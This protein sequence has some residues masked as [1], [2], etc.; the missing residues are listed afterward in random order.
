M[1]PSEW[2]RRLTAHYLREDGPFGGAPLDWIDATPAELASAAGMPGARDE[3]VQT[4]FLRQFSY[5]DAAGWLDGR[6]ALPPRDQDVPGYFRYLVLTALVL[7]TDHG[8]GQT[9]DFRKRLGELLGHM[10]AMQAVGGVNRLWGELAAWSEARRAAGHPI[11]RVILPDPGGMTRIGVA[12]RIAF[13][14]WKDRQI[15]TG[16]LARL[17]PPMR[18]SPHRLVAELSRPQYN[19]VCSPNVAATFD[20]FAAGLA[21]G[22]ADLADHRFWRLVES[23]SQR[24]QDGRRGAEIDRW[25][26]EVV[27][28]GIERDAVDV[29][30]VRR[31]ARVQA[32]EPI[33]TGAFDDFVA[34]ESRALPGRLIRLREGGVILLSEIA[35]GAWAIDDL[36]ASASW[37]SVVLSLAD[38]PATRAGLATSWVAVGGGW[39]AS[40]PVAT[41]A[42]LAALAGL[43][44]RPPSSDR[45]VDLGLEGGVSTARGSWLGRP[46]Y[47]PRVRAPSGATLTVE[48]I[49]GD[50]TSLGIDDRGGLSAEAPLTGAWKLTAHF[51]GG[52]AQ[53]RFFLEADASERDA[54]RA[55]GSGFEV[56]DEAQVAGEAPRAPAVVPALRSPTPPLLL[57]LMETVYARGAA[58]WGEAEFVELLDPVLPDRRGA[59][60]VMRAFAEAGWAEAGI[61]RGWRARRWRLLP[62]RLVPIGARTAL[63]EGAICA[64]ARRRLSEAARTQGGEVSASADLVWSPDVVIARDIDIDVMAGAMGW[65]VEVDTRPVLAA[66][67]ACWTPETRTPDGRELAG[68]WS[69]EAGGFRQ[70]VASDDAWRLER[71]TRSRGDDRDLFRLCGP[72]TTWCTSVRTAAIVEA[73]RRARR[74]L[75]SWDAGALI[76]VLP[77]GHLPM[78]LARAL[79]RAALRQTGPIEAGG[80]RAYR[81]PADREAA[82]WVAGAMGPAVSI[83]A[84][85]AARDLLG[86]VVG[87]RRR[88]RPAVWPPGALTEA[89]R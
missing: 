66:A 84:T 25:R 64:A 29:R 85:D 1:S 83:P 31:E 73:H 63:V 6:Y 79:R 58:S 19:G 44:V 76:S 56:V 9:R 69:F 15:L 7:S 20:D 3:D 40:E 57:D 50:T 14:S 70:A 77:G 60:D 51:P 26:F 18:R 10:G 34:A 2:E 35:G 11:R 74:P 82:A 17:T 71:W 24:L 89:L 16:I 12:V 59:W 41:P 38:G 87:A 68:V 4:A 5:W 88:G 32:A 81:Y 78:P 27:F 72:D 21:A 45:L 47:L 46:G 48:Q 8:A 62:P 13:P 55:M 22:R 86:L 80:G 33:W 42:A 54:W 67:P 52:D 23:V 65:P 28:S 36:G 49:A 30:V 43:G 75:F 39:Q 37:S 53:R 61:S